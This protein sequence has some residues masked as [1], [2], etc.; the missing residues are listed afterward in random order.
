M[1]TYD[2]TI[3]VVIP[4]YNRLSFLK[5]CLESLSNQT[6]PR[7]HYEIIIVDDGSRNGTADYVQS[8]QERPNAPKVVYIRQSNRGPAAARNTGVKRAKG[9]IIAFIDDDCI[10][11]YN[12]L[13][14]IT[15]VFR[16][17]SDVSAC[18]TPAYSTE[19]IHSNNLKPHESKY[20][21]FEYAPLSLI[22]T[23]NCA[24]YK[25]VFD[26][27]GGFD[28]SFSLTGGEDPD[29]IYTLLARGYEVFQTSEMIVYHYP[30]I[31]AKTVARQSFIFGF[32]D[33]FVLKKHFPH[34]FIIE[35][36]FLK[37]F[38]MHRFY[39][40]KNNSVAGCLRMDVLKIIL[41]GI[42][43]AYISLKMA[44]LLFYALI[45]AV[46]ISGRNLRDILKSAKYFLISDLFYLLG[47][48]K[49]SFKAKIFYF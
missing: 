31:A 43:I 45:C 18:G 29:L 40:F 46:L 32:T 7:S 44:L 13:E 38:K 49:G 28:E 4:T 8:F 21:K 25:D 2:H 6:W 10:A 47:H 33:C 30:K 42:I 34:Q 26:K 41:A 20:L 16:E 39:Y 23:N 24:I 1:V 37:V 27:I 35:L 5:E 14:S 17:K 12:W 22:S 15:G 48:L 11:S 3:S 19:D 9:D 36:F